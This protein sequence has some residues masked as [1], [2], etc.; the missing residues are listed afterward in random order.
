M[1]EARS[2]ATSRRLL[3]IVQCSIQSSLRSYRPSLLIQSHLPSLLDLMTFSKYTP[4]RP[5]LRVAMKQQKSPKGALLWELEFDSEEPPSPVITA[6][7]TPKDS[8][9]S[10]VH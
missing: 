5:L 1:S 7:A 9:T 4:A 2:E 10:A 3:V 6:M 8:A